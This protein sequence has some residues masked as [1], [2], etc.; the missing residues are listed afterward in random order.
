MTRARRLTVALLLVIGILGFSMLP[1]DVKQAIGTEGRMHR[2]LHVFAFGFATLVLTRMVHS[3]R[4]RFA[5]VA[6]FLLVAVASELGECLYYQNSMFEWYDLKDDFIGV[7]GG[8]AISEL[9]RL[10]A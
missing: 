1:W 4:A 7:A 9:F 10:R 5:V 8:L 2:Y 6:G 3:S